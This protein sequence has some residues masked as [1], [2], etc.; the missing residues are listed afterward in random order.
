MDTLLIE[1]LLTYAEI[2]KLNV[3]N[4][5]KGELSPVEESTLNQLINEGNQL[6]ELMCK[7]DKTEEY[8]EYIEKLNENIDNLQMQFVNRMYEC[9]KEFA[10]SGTM[11]SQLFKFKEDK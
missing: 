2:Y 1:Y 11:I 8:D 3:L 10:K 4:I 7:T 6:M 9:I 5:F